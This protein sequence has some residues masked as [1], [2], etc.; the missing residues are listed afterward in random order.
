MI[1][2]EWHLETD[3][4]LLGRKYRAGT[5]AE[6]G[7]IRFRKVLIRPDGFRR[8]QRPTWP[9][10]GA[11]RATGPVMDSVATVR[12]CNCTAIR[13]TASIA[14]RRNYSGRATDWPCVS[15]A[16]SI[17]CRNDVVTGQ[18]WPSVSSKPSGWPNPAM[19]WADAEDLAK[20]KSKINFWNSGEDSGET[21][22]F[23]M[24]IHR[25]WTQLQQC[26]CNWP[27]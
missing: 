22:K 1:R 17:R 6:K 2:P 26:G 5:G 12:S 8:I 19:E 18:D 25:N 11:E 21:V 23:T 9:R 13:R 10:D 3:D 16:N 4:A 24:R 27:E 7:E 14:T 20:K 15:R